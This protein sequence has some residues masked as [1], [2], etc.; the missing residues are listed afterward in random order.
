MVDA[1]GAAH[2]RAGDGVVEQRALDELDPV[3]AVDVGGVPGGQ[4]VEHPDGALGG[5]VAHE[6]GADEARAPDDERGAGH[7]V[8][9]PVV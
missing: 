4:V 1:V 3:D 7:V 6:R 9:L 2:D 8:V 5:E